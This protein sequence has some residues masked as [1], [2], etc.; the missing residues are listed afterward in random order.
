MQAP[1]RA[2]VR[3]IEPLRATECAHPSTAFAQDS[4]SF[5]QNCPNCF[6]LLFLQLKTTSQFDQ[7]K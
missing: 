3:K 4:S 1:G 2:L 5:A 6:L 7:D